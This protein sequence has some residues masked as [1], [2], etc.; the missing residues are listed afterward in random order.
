MEIP[1]NFGWNL[2]ARRKCSPVTAW[3]YV[4]T[5]IVLT[6]A[7]TT[8]TSGQSSILGQNSPG[9]FLV[10][11]GGLAVAIDAKIGTERRRQTERHYP[12]QVF[13][14]LRRLGLLL[15]GKLAPAPSTSAKNAAT[16][17]LDETVDRPK[18]RLALGGM[19]RIDYLLVYPELHDIVICG[20]GDFIKYEDDQ[21]IGDSNGLPCLTIEDLRSCWE[22][23]DKNRAKP[24]GCSI[25][26]TASGLQKLR[27]RMLAEPP[28]S[29]GDL[30]AALGRQRIDL[31]LL[32][33]KYSIGHSIVA[34]D[35]RLK[36][37]AL[38][39]E[40]TGRF[41]LPPVQDLGRVMEG[42]IPRV[43]VGTNYDP[44]LRSADRRAWGIHGE[45][46]VH[47]DFPNELEP[48][49]TERR[50]IEAWCKQWTEA[51]NDPQFAA[52]AFQHVRGISD[53]AVIV[54]LIQRYD[55]L[56]KPMSNARWTKS[57]RDIP[58]RPVPRWTESLCRIETKPRRL[59]AGGV[60]LAPWEA[61]AI[62]EDSPQNLQL[63]RAGTP[64][65]DET[66]WAW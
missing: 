17:S 18:H 33:G 56:P 36:R 63:W 38:G 22:L 64:P 54:A 34:A 62:C 13:V 57:A 48:T 46:E 44:I 21:P 20:R 4:A 26:P 7:L 25:G 53:L 43:W 5:T 47:L 45:F 32:S 37:L 6:T 29:T 55:L 1:M 66:I 31:I 27:Q 52:P 16:E 58:A 59:V 50:R 3:L 24:F 42:V 60:L 19:Q 11:P 65:A 2:R 12:A 39:I 10:D 23:V 8:P 28:P 15:S 51:V 61:T 30:S 40:S 14:S 49:S 35:V 41:K 9:G